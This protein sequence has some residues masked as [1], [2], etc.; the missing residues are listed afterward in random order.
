LKDQVL[1]T[2]LQ[3]SLSKVLHFGAGLFLREALF[4]VHIFKTY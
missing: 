2:N 1:Q 4:Y 3:I